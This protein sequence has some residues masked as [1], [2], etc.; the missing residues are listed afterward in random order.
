MLV[1]QMRPLRILVNSTTRM[2]AEDVN[3][4]VVPRNT[5]DD[6]LITEDDVVDL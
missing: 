6:D 3:T 4:Q 5:T 1:D 2:V